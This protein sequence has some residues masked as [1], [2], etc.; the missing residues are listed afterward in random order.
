R[1][2][3]T[4]TI[5]KLPKSDRFFGITIDEK[6]PR[7][8]YRKKIVYVD[9]RIIQIIPQDTLPNSAPQPHQAPP[10]S[11]PSPKDPP[12]PKPQ[13]LRSQFQGRRRGRP[14]LR[15]KIPLPP[16]APPSPSRIARTT[17]S[18]TSFDVAGEGKIRSRIS[19][20]STRTRRFLIPNPRQG[21]KNP[22]QG[23][24]PT[25][26]TSTLSRSR[27]KRGK[28]VRS[29]G[30]N[31]PLRSNTTIK[32]SMVDLAGSLDNRLSPKSA[33]TSAQKPRRRRTLVLAPASGGEGQGGE[34]SLRGGSASRASGKGSRGEKSRLR[35]RMEIG[36]GGGRAGSTGGGR[37]KGGIDGFGGD[38]RNRPLRS[39]VRTTRSSNK[40]SLRTYS[41]RDRSQKRSR[42]SVYPSRR[43]SKRAR[44]L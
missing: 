15:S 6:L 29:E 32:S 22:T 17:R 44:P 18:G 19:R 16:Q 28:A 31:R 8:Q 21:R 13:A 10:P 25:T 20:P 35:L 5:A 33:L 3:K 42:D 30:W 4:G 37:R 36:K 26:P 40:T 23:P 7:H 9:A 27:R 11:K 2:W 43:V 12:N 38:R 41:T 1:T 24:S 39:N 14:R 34:G